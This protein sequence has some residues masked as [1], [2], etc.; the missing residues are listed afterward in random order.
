M[1][2]NLKVGCKVDRA[3]VFPVVSSDRTR[4]NGHRLKQGRFLPN[5]RTHFFI[6]R[7]RGALAEVAQR[8]A[9]VS[10]LGRSSK[11]I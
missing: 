1:G 10:I 2:K 7:V 3:R 9:G 6:V 11:A 8:A 5:I 4:G